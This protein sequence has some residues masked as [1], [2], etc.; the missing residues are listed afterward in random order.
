MCRLWKLSVT[1]SAGEKEE[2]H[3]RAAVSIAKDGYNE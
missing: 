2:S 1:E 3:S